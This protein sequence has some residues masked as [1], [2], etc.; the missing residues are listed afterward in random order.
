MTK[1][2]KTQA[3]GDTSRPSTTQEKSDL[4]PQALL[5][6]AV[7]VLPS[8]GKRRSHPSTNRDE[9]DLNPQPA[10]EKAAKRK[11]AAPKQTKEPR[12]RGEP[13]EDL[14]VFAFRLTV[15]EREAIHR[16]AGAAKAS[17]F[18]RTLAVAAAHRDEA[19][20]RE[21]VKFAGTTS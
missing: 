12:K 15:E 18:V 20:V 8:K 13:R 1:S 6:G 21:L 11:A 19:K 17:R 4:N 14:V 16:A 2:K 3:G 9:S 7:Q 10:S 5:A